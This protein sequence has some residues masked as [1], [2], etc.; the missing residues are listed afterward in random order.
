MH[1]DVLGKLWVTKDQHVEVLLLVIVLRIAKFRFSHNL[2]LEEDS[3]CIDHV[4][5]LKSKTES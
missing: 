1:Q 5:E 4:L 2:I 3:F